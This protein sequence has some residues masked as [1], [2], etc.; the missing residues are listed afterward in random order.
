MRAMCFNWKVLAGLGAVGVGI[1]LVNP[2]LVLGALPLL[3]LA[4]CPLSMLLMGKSMMGGM[5]HG[6]AGEQQPAVPAEG[7]GAV[8]RAAQLGQLRAQLQ[9][10]D[11][12][13]AALSARLAQLQ[14]T[15][16]EAAPPRTALI[17]AEQVAQAAATRP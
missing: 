10:L 4:A 5:H 13:Q 7:G 15:E 12:Q 6:G 17:Q 16:A 3:V 11:E 8:S 2:G 14:A 9:V 1:Y